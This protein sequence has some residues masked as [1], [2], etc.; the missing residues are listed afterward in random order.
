MLDNKGNENVLG[1]VIEKLKKETKRQTSERKKHEMTTGIPWKVCNT[2]F[3]KK[4][5]I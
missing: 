3:R 2:S 1:T 4:V 5:Y